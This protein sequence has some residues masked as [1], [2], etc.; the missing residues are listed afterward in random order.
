MDVSLVGK[1]VEIGDALRIH[2][3]ESLTASVTKY[4]GRPIEASVTLSR[5]AHGFHA[6]VS[7]HAARGVLVQGRA[8]AADPYAAC[9]GAIERTAKQLRR[10][11]RKIRD[12][13][14]NERGGGR[15]AAAEGV[16]EAGLED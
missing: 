6:D 14:K 9:D 13:H 2:V 11:K 3:Q 4:F 10:Q 5:A 1:H 15:A 8:D 7:V 12:H 16:R